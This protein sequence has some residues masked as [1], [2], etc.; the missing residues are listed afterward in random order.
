MLW[1]DNF[2]LPANSPNQYTAGL[3]LNF[4]LRPEISAEIANFNHYATPN[5]A[6]FQYIEPDIFNDPVIFPSNEEL[7]NAEILLPLSR[8]TEKYYE[9]VWERFLSSQP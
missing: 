9:E 6:A 1:G 2:V 8:E 7:K 5:E 3:F 4:L